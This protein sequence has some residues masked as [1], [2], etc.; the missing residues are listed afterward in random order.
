[1]QACSYGLEW[2][3]QLACHGTVFGAGETQ[4]DSA[5]ETR[6]EVKDMLRVS[7]ALQ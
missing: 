7:N 6:Q 3:E 5:R 1:M 2:T 4:V